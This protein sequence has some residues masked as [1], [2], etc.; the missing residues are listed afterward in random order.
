[1]LNTYWLVG[2][3]P[4]FAY[5]FANHNLSD[6]PIV[7][8]TLS[9]AR[10]ATHPLRNASGSGGASYLRLPLSVAVALGVSIDTARSGRECR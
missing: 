9:V 5:A 7:P 3:N 10:L 8:I 2:R 6:G 1:M 4:G